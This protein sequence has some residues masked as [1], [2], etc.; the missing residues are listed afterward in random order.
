MCI[1][2]R[3]WLREQARL[4][5]D[6][7]LAIIAEERAQLLRAERRLRQVHP[8]RLVELQVQRLDERQLRLGQAIGRRVERTTARLALARARLTA[9][10]PRAVLMRGYSIVQR[11][12]GEVVTAPAQSVAGE[13]LAVLSAGVEEHAPFA[14]HAEVTRARAFAPACDLCAARAQCPGVDAGYLA[15]FGGEELTA[16]A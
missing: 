13:T 7:A 15:R 2:D 10:D 8:I 4:C 9:F 14:A 12:S 6:E 11:A 16:I 5:A 1:R 3:L